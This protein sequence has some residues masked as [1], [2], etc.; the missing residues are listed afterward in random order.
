M[1]VKTKKQ[2]REEE[3]EEDVSLAEQLE[4]MDRSA[5]KKLIKD[6]EL[7]IKVYKSTDDDDLRAA[8]LAELG[9][10]EAEEDDESDDEEASAES[11][12][13]VEEDDEGDDEDE[14]DLD[15]LDRSELK[16]FIKENRLEV[17]IKKKD[18]DD[19]IREK[20][21]AAVDALESEDDGEDEDESPAARRKNKEEDKRGMDWMFTGDKMKQEAQTS[22]AT[23]ARGYPPEFWVKDGGTSVVRFRE[24]DPIVGMYMYSYHNGKRWAKCTQPTDTSEDRFAADGRRAAYYLVYELLDRTGYT[25]KEGKKVSNIPRYWFVSDKIHKQL[26]HIRDKKG[27]LTKF[28]IEVHREGGN[29]PV[30]TFMLDDALGKL[31]STAKNLPSLKG[32]LKKYYTPPTVE[33]QRRMLHT[34]EEAEQSED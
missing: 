3:S 24:D 32:D 22:A 15:D 29:R 23:S 34:S 4:D 30:Y 19:D 26:Q 28:D 2:D 31:P 17:S 5:L 11:E 14:V 1:K 25:N 18:D 12:D 8:I 33:E 6:E 10:S 21:K 7:E 16:A 27:S 20:I 13:E 9:E